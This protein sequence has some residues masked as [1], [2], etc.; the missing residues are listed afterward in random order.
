[1]GAKNLKHLGDLKLFY[2]KGE[3]GKSHTFMRITCVDCPVTDEVVHKPDVNP[4]YYANHFSRKGWNV[5]VKLKKPLCPT[6]CKPARKAPANS[7]VVQ[8]PNTEPAAAE[9]RDAMFQHPASLGGVP[10]TAATEGQALTVAEPKLY[11]R[12]EKILLAET[13]LDDTFIRLPG[14]LGYYRQGASDAKGA[15]ASQLPEDEFFDIRIKDYGMLVD[16]PAMFDQMTKFGMDLVAL[17][18]QIG[19]DV[20]S[21]VAKASPFGSPDVLP[22]PLQAFLSDKR[23][24]SNTFILEWKERLERCV[25]K[26]EEDQNAYLDSLESELQAKWKEFAKTH[27]VALQ[28]LVEGLQPRLEEVAKMREQVASMMTSLSP[29]MGSPAA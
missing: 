15:A 20:Q 2:K 4:L 6:C 28:P 29:F 14:G 1:M 11:K 8:I 7:N 5:D 22:V 17:Q 9:R 19:E 12:S 18:K 27:Q 21:M 13:Y 16:F 3:D 23:N 26:A 24:M 25:K 10:A